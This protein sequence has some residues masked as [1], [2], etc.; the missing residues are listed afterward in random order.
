MQIFYPNWI[1]QNFE[2]IQ[3]ACV[4]RLSLTYVCFGGVSNLRHSGTGCQ[5][6][7]VVARMR[8]GETPVNSDAIFEIARD[9]Y[10]ENTTLQDV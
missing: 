3:T 6:A 1:L 7:Q 5:S 2:E 9:P 4:P 10:A 8:R